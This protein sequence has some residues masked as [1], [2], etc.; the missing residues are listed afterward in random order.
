MYP[1]TLVMVWLNT[2][3][4]ISCVSIRHGLYFKLTL[5]LSTHLSALNFS[6]EL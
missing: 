3:L 4:R 2:T 5:N 1:S 6:F